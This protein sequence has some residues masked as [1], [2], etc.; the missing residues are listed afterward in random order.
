MTKKKVLHLS[1]TH[2]EPVEILFVGWFDDGAERL[3][4]LRW[5]EG[6]RP[7][8]FGTWTEIFEIRSEEKVRSHYMFKEDMIIFYLV[9]FT[10]IGIASTIRSDHREY[11]VSTG[12]D[13]ADLELV[14]KSCWSPPGSEE[15]WSSPGFQYFCFRE[16]EDASIGKS[17]S[18]HKNILKS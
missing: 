14:R 18:S 6:H 1:E 10:R 15:F 17:V 3:D 7:S 16:G 4:Y 13:I 9:P 8:D 5:V 11:P 2:L 12:R